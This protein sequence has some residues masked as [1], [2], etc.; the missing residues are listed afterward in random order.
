MINHGIK[1]A[2]MMAFR[3]F[4][5]MSQGTGR[6]EAMIRSARVGDMI[7]CATAVERRHVEN[8]LKELKR[9]GVK[10]GFSDPKGDPMRIRGTNPTGATIFSHLFIEQFWEHRL[11]GI[12][13]E[14]R[15]YQG[16]LSKL[17]VPGQ[18]IHPMAARMIDLERREAPLP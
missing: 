9:T 11:E 17:D 1:A 8:R 14:L 6:T 16:A 4:A 18:D 3:V 12:D 10:V 2:V 13:R 5:N 15:F 7:L